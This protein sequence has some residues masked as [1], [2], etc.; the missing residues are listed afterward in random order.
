M[1]VLKDTILTVGALM[2]GSIC[3]AVLLSTIFA[4][5]L[6]YGPDVFLTSTEDYHGRR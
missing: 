3:A 6:R 2:F 4:N 1:K 5:V